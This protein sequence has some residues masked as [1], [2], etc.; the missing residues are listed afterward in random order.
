LECRGM[1]ERVKRDNTIIICIARNISCACDGR[2]RFNLR[3]AV[4]R[5]VGGNS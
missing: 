4:R 3:S 2:R 1:L 5:I